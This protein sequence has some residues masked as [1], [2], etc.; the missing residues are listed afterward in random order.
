MSK[1]YATQKRQMQPAGK[2]LEAWRSC[3]TS[4]SQVYTGLTLSDG[5]CQQVKSARTMWAFPKHSCRELKQCFVNVLISVAGHPTFRLKTAR[6]VAARQLEIACFIG[7][8]KAHGGTRQR[9]PVADP[10]HIQRGELMLETPNTRSQ[11]PS[12]STARDV[13]GWK[14]G[15]SST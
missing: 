6:T 7:C 9:E 8:K 12:P 15:A 11:T 14:T 10:S 1:T 5:S 2:L 4:S 13:Q 3:A